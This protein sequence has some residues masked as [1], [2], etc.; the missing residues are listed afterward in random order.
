MGEGWGDWYAL[1]YLHRQGLTRSRSSASTPPATRP[2]A[3][4][5]GPTTHN[6]TTFGDI[7]YDLTGPEVHAD[8]EIWTAT[9][10]E[11]RKKL[12]AQYGQAQGLRGRRPSRHRRD[13][14]VGTRP[15]VPRHA[16]RD[17]RRGRSTATTATTPTRSGASSPTAAPA[18][19]PRRRPVTTPTRGPRST[20]RRTR[21][22]ARSSAPSST[23]STGAPVKNAKV[24]VGEFEAR[25]T[26]LARTSA[27]AA[28]ARRWRRQLRRCSIQA[29]GFGAQTFKDVAVDRRRRPPRLR[30]R[31][32]RTWRRWPSGAT[33]VSTSSEDAGLP[34]K[35][36]LDDTAASVWSTK[37]GATPYN[38]GPDQRVTVKLAKPTHHQPAPDQ[39]LQEHHRQPVRGP[40]GLHLPGVRRR[41]DVEDREDRWL[42]LPGPAADGPRP[43][44]T[45]TFTL[46]TPTKASYVRF[47]IDSVQGETIDLRAGGRA[48]VF[49]AGARTSRPSRRRPTHRSPTRARSPSATPRRATRPVCRTSAASPATSSSKPAPHRRPRRVPTAGCPRCPGA[50]ATARTPSRSPAARHRPG[51]TSTCTS[52]RVVRADR[53]DRH[54]GAPTSR[55]SSPAGRPTS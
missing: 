8:G 51:T 42:R 30:S 12:V 6:P 49:G 4:A 36:L 1:N 38:T 20:T 24:I 19:R 40:E 45:Q 35:F 37:K 11:L 39:R 44:T 16:R 54:L 53:V 22:T 15:V 46:A 33:V 27:P 48:Q 10:W 47:F 18:P 34:A 17:P 14:A 41:R 29:P 25:V 50:S 52:T 7:G 55:A 26:P 43:A 9:L 3:S 21:A 5:T 32:H 28:S 23:P 13:A 31:S 2:G